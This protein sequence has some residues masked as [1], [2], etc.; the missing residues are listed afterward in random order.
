M[1][2]HEPG[3]ADRVIAKLTGDL[4]ERG[5]VAVKVWKA[6]GMMLRDPDGRYVHCDDDRFRPI[7]DFLEARR[8][9]VILHLADPRAAWEPLD[10]T[11]PP[12]RLL[13][14][15]TRNTISTAVRTC[16]ATA[17]SSNTATR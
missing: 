8:I 13:Q 4:D 17:R 11:S 12:L 14:P 3:Y 6:I 15:P 7:Y 10:P 16:P 9:P 5:A 2:S 1:A